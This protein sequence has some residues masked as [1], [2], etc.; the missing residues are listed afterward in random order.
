MNIESNQHKLMDLMSKVLQF[1]DEMEHLEAC[2]HDL[3]EISPERLEFIRDF[4]TLLAVAISFI[5]IAFY[6]Y[7]RIQRA[8]GAADYLA[9]IDE[10]PDYGIAYLGYAQLVSALLLLVGFSYN[11]NSIIVQQG[12]RTKTEANKKDLIDDITH[13]LN[14]YQPKYGE[15]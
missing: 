4:S 15:I 1:N 2:S 9:Y 7:D 8:D 12:W 11:N 5:C 13:I 6:R 14:K 10:I 3:I